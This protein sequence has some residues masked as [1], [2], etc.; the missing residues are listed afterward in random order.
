[1]QKMTF[2]NTAAAVAIVLGLAAVPALS[3]DEDG[4]WFGSWGMGHMMGHG[5]GMGHGWRRG[6]GSMMGFWQDSMLDRIDGRLAF[7]KTELKITDAQQKQWDELANTVR[8]TAEAHNAMMRDRMEEM[9]SGK[10]FEKPLPD[11]LAIQE[12]HLESRLQQVKDVRAALDKL[13]AVLDNDQKKTADEIVLPM[14]GMGMGM[15]G[16]GMRGMMRDD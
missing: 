12:T 7:L 9:H 11:R 14:M 10:F 5:W 4:G 8:T 13:Y 16:R 6:P 15:M 3:H 1:M 2:L